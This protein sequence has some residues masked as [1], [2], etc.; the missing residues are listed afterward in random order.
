MNKET[1]LMRRLQLAATTLGSRLLRNN[2]GQTVTKDGRVIRYGL[3]VGSSDLIGWTPVRI[4]PEHVGQTLA[5]FTAVEVKVPGSYPTKQQ[6]DFLA[7][8]QAAGGIG[9][10][11]RNEDDLRRGILR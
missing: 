7:A 11:A 1:P 4:G 3:A 2:V 6:R 5:V 8:V 10:V 9:L